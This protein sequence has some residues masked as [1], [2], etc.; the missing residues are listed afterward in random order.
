MNTIDSFGSKLKYQ[1]YCFVYKG[2]HPLLITVFI[3]F[4]QQNVK[5]CMTIFSNENLCLTFFEI[6]RLPRFTLND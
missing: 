6:V 1:V 4:L 2:V 3:S 5:L